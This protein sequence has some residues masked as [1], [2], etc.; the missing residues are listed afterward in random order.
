MHWFRW[1]HGSVTDPKFQLVARRAG[2]SLP[3]V[4]AVWAY[5]L[6]QASASADRGSPGSVDAEA[7]D[8]LF[9]FP[10]TD[11]RTADILAAMEQRGLTLP[12]GS[13]ASWSKRQPRR[14]REDDTAAERKRRQRE[15]ASMPPQDFDTPEAAGQECDPADGGVMG[16]EQPGHT[17]SRHVTPRGEERR[18]EKNTTSLRSVVPRE[19]RA[20]A[21]GDLDL[22]GVSAELLA[23][24]VKVRKAKRA[25]PLTATAV[26]GLAREAE[27]AGVTVAE[28]V[29]A[30]CERGWQSFNAG[31][32]SNR[33][34]VP[35]RTSVTEP[36]W[37]AE[38]RQRT[39][40]AAPGIAA[41]GGPT[42]TQFFTDV[43]ARHVAPIA[44]D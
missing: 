20:A 35:A 2:A 5:L 41:K 13:I 4:L 34:G 29:R 18:G 24:W 39:H 10:A 25:G 31:W 38:Q 17:M 9:G 37:R 27:R 1:H 40:Q 14:E 11:T 30:C 36:A 26:A 23:D 3:D 6:E 28:A 42:A 15:L 19:A 43:E 44:L 32:H 21:S 7:L 22:P 8:C 12:D 33:S 16:E